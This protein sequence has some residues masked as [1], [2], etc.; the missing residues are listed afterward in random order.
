MQFV[1]SLAGRTGGAV[2][3]PGST[4]AGGVPMP[5]V[6]ASA[7]VPDAPRA[8]PPPAEPAGAT[9][10]AAV[11]SRGPVSL[12]GTWADTRGATYEFAQSRTDVQ[13]REI[14]RIVFIPVE[15]ANCIG[16]VTGSQ[17]VAQ[18]VTYVG[19]QGEV[20]LSLSDAGSLVGEYRDFTAGGVVPMMLTR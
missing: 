18:C 5:E 3:D 1:S 19:T 4:G 6:G 14:S 13:I 12:G 9:P 8:A 7:Y 15:T 11:T 16:T 20:R 2:V 10:A 17:V